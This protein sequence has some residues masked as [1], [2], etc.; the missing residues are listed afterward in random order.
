MSCRNDSAGLVC[1]KRPTTVIIAIALVKGV[2]ALITRQDKS[3]F[4]KLYFRQGIYIF[5]FTAAFCYR[6]V[7]IS[8][9]L[10]N[11]RVTKCNF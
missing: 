7:C 3:G 9:V 6:N 4:G 8:S 10:I 5:I 2:C 1:Y 11:I